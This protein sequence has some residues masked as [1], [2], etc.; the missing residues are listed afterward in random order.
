M[1]VLIIDRFEGNYAICEDKE[2]K[3]F[4]IDISE[5][6][7]GAREGDVLEISD[8]GQLTLNA[9]KT[10]DRRSKMKKLQDKLWE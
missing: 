9:E 3:Y 1:K 4:G 10:A 2:R 8:D 5:L 6:P 7:K